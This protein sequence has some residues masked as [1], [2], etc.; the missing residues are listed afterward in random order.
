MNRLRLTFVLAVAILLVFC[1][2]SVSSLRQWLGFQPNVLPS[3]M[4]YCALATDLTTWCS[5]A[6]VG[7]LCLDS[8]SINPLGV[9]SIGLLAVGA[10]L[11]HQRELIVYQ[12]WSVQC[13]LGLA[14]TGGAFLVELSV[15]SVLDIHPITGWITWWQG[16]GVTVGG[17]LMAPLWFWLMPFLESSFGY[18]RINPSSFRADREI[19]RGRF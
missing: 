15:Q 2:S 17:A 10:C 5:L 1:Q 11:H 7:G 18:S 9:S 13:L 8:L 16:G 14:A 19:K 6:L 3:L 12:D 4:V